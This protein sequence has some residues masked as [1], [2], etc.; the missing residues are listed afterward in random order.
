MPE[1]RRH[2]RLTFWRRR[3]APGLACIEVVELVTLYLE[4]AMG[5]EERRAFEAHIDQC[6]HCSAYLDQMRQT[7]AVAGRI[8]PDELADETV[9]DLVH[10]FRE[11]SRA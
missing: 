6:P 1:R 3:S 7:L 11:W 10:A 9:E 4:D 2:I 8:D 5:P